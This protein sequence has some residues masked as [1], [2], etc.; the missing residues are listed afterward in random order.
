MRKLLFLIVL[1]SAISFSTYATH[2]IGGYISYKHIS[3]LTYEITLVTYSNDLSVAADRCE[4]AV[5][6]GDG[7]SQMVSR[8]NGPSCTGGQSSCNHC[9]EIVNGT[10]AVK[11]NIYKT[12]HTYPSPNTYVISMLD[13]NRNAG[14]VNIP[15]SVQEPLYIETELVIL[16]NNFVNNSPILL[17][18]PLILV[19]SSIEIHQNLSAYDMDGDILSYE[20]VS[21]KSSGGNDIPGYFIPDS[22]NIELV[23]GELT[24]K[25]LPTIGNYVVTIKIK[26]CRDGQNIG[27]VL[28]D[29]QVSVVTTPTLPEFTGLSNWPTDYFGRYSVTI[30]PTD[31]IDLDIT[32]KDNY[33]LAQVGLDANSETFFTGQNSSFTVVSNSQTQVTKKYKW[34]PNSSNVRC[35]PYLVTFKGLS[36]YSGSIY[37]DDVTLMVFVKDQS[38]PSCSSVCGGILSIDEYNSTNF[39]ISISPNP[40]LD[41]AT[42]TIESSNQIGNLE[43]ELFDL[44][45]RKVRTIQVLNRSQITFYRNGLPAGVYLYR[46]VGNDKTLGSGKLV[47]VD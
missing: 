7:T 12:Q 28:V 11:R 22:V 36:N 20:L 46:V 15:N 42:I 6:F 25:N 34:K 13:P 32:F 30:T 35:A 21:A 24:W 23:N 9:G 8:I 29:I 27:Y 40:V 19:N 38:L 16:S 39:N 31:S 41:E 18:P 33:S 37:G 2:N 44:L 3:G 1:I 45:G 14:I 5:K 17:G 47:F 4:L 26:E 10:I 43:F